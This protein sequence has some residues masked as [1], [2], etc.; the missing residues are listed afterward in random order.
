MIASPIVRYLFLIIFLLT[1]FDIT[2]I[3]YYVVDGNDV[4]SFQMVEKFDSNTKLSLCFEESRVDVDKTHMEQLL[5]DG[6]V[7]VKIY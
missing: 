7:S 4:Q 2:N 6:I 3:L 5:S 1:I